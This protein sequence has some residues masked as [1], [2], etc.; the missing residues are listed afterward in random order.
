MADSPQPGYALSA[1]VYSSD[2]IQL[3]NG[4]QGI[5][6]FARIQNC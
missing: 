1:S 5:D 6:G 4:V 3:V 2:G